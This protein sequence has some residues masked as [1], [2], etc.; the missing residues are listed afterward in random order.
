[1]SPFFCFFASSFRQQDKTSQ[2]QLFFFFLGLLSVFEM[3]MLL[4]RSGIIIFHDRVIH[5]GSKE[6]K[7]E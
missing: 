3:V 4:Q 5:G 7:A 1:M 2:N 6:K